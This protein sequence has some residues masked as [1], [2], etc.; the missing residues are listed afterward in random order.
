MSQHKIAESGLTGNPGQSQYLTNPI[1]ASSLTFNLS[2]DETA[3]GT[4]GFS[5][6]IEDSD[7]RL[8]EMLQAQTAHRRDGFAAGDEDS[9]AA[10]EK[11]SDEEKRAILQGSLHMAASNG[12]VERVQRLVNGEAKRYIDVNGADEE[13]TAP[14][15]YASC[16]VSSCIH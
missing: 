13:G 7:T 2:L 4:D 10:D 15:I 8:V 5:H 6:Q 16:F 14:L 3:Y 1:P 9:I 11:L 12:D